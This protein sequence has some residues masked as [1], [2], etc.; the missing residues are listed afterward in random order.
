MG[1]IFDLEEDFPGEIIVGSLGDNYSVEFRLGFLM[2]EENLV[3]MSITLVEGLGFLDGYDGIYDLRFGIRTKG[4]KHEWRVSPMDFT[5]ESS[6][7]F[8]PK[9]RMAVLQLTIR[10][11][12]ILVSHVN[13]KV[14]TMSTF[15][16]DP[17]SAALVKYDL[18]EI[19]LTSLGYKRLEKYRSENGYY[20]WHFC[21]PLD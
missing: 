4:L 20:R 15:Y 2:E 17:P 21:L 3:V 18:I 7:L 19:C 14:I 5:L 10:A 13:P 8:V 1:Y 6:R 9:F 16:S 11:I 12:G